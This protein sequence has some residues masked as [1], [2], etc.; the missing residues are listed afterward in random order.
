MLATQAG[1]GREDGQEQGR[2]IFLPIDP[3]E[4][5]LP[6]HEVLQPGEPGRGHGVTGFPGR[7]PEPLLAED[8]IPAAE[9]GQLQPGAAEQVGEPEAGGDVVAPAG[10]EIRVPAP[11]VPQARIRRVDPQAGEIGIDEVEAAAGPQE[12][13]QV[14]PRTCRSMTTSKAPGASPV[15]AASPWPK[16][17][18]VTPESPTSR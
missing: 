16:D 9:A 7:S 3:L 17:T 12:R 18:L 8:V 13:P 6:A 11:H 2:G 4:G 14:C 1:R 10:L 5:L 15:E